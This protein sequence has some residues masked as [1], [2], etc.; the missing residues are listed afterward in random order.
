MYT[1]DCKAF[2]YMGKSFIREIVNLF[3]YFLLNE[4]SDYLFS[5]GVVREGEVDLFI[6]EFLALFERGIIGLVGAGNHC[7]PIIF[8]PQFI[9]FKISKDL[10]HLRAK[11]SSPIFFLLLY[12]TK[13]SLKVINHDDCRL[14]L[15]GTND[16]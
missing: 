3:A 6:E 7:N 16:D 4:V 14:V 13:D 1:S 8:S 10:L 15:L 9:F 2:A 5:S 12:S 11:G